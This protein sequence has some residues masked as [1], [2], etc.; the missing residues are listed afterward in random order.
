M[1]GAVLG[2]SNRVDNFDDELNF[3]RDESFEHVTPEIYRVLV[4]I[5]SRNDNCATFLEQVRLIEQMW[6]L[7]KIGNYGCIR[8]THLCNLYLLA[9]IFISWKGGLKE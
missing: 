8:I 5:Y 9:L 6:Y 1:S 2:T 7:F 4:H 3:E